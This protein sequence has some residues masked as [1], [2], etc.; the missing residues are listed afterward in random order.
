M[1]IPAAGQQMMQPAGP[2]VGRGFP[3]RAGHAAA[4]PEQQRHAAVAGFGQKVLRIH[5]LDQIAAVR[6]DADRLPAFGHQPLVGL[7]AVEH[8]AAA[9]DVI[10]AHVAQVQRRGRGGLGFGQRVE[11]RGGGG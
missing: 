5:L 6:V 10:G 7:A 4:V 3:G 2:A 9:A 8:Y 1:A 11:V